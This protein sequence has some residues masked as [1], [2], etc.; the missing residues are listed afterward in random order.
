MKRA[1]LE[2]NAIS[3]AADEFISG[4]QLRNILRSRGFTPVIGFHTIYELAKTFLNESK[5]EVAKELFQIVVALEAEYCEESREILNQ[6]F[7]HCFERNPINPFLDG[8]KKTDTL[9]E[10]RKLAD[11]VFDD[12]ARNFIE[13]REKNFR[14]DHP[15]ISQ[16]NIQDFAKNPPTNRLRTFEEVLAYYANDIPSMVIQIFGGKPSHEQAQGV[17]KLLEH[18]PAIRAAVRANMFLIYVQVVQ[19]VVPA[20]DKV[21]DHRHVIEASYCDAFITSDT[22]LLRNLKKI[23]PCLEPVS[24][25]TLR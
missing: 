7:N 20:T 11:G 25:Q 6:E 17:F 23:N 2:T 18:Y 1:Y 8:C 16:N 19:K 21:D 12:C 22:Q 5:G 9:S 4:Q 3:R 24:W 13:A 14:I 15:Q 10:V